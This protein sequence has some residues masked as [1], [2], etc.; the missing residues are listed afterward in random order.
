RLLGLPLFPTRRSSDLPD[1][2]IGHQPFHRRV[3]QREEAVAADGEADARQNRA[4]R[5]V[6]L[7]GHVCSA[8]C[9]AASGGRGMIV[10]QLRSLPRSEEHT[11]ELQSRENLV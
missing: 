10:G 1:R 3:L 11:S 6:A 2:M 7:E 5:L 8:G 4:V 9:R